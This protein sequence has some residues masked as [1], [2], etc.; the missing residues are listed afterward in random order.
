M[1]AQLPAVLAQ[2]MAPMAPA[3]SVVHKIIAAS[4]PPTTAPLTAAQLRE[5]RHDNT[6]RRMGLVL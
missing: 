4:P 1:N 2:A 5:L 3:Q 6:L